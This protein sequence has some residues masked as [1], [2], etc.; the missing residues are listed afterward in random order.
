MEYTG[1]TIDRC[2]QIRWFV[3]MSSEQSFHFKIFPDSEGWRPWDIVWSLRFKGN[4]FTIKLLCQWSEVLCWKLNVKFYSVTTIKTL[5]QTQAV[6]LWFK[7]LQFSSQSRLIRNTDCYVCIMIRNSN[8]FCQWDPYCDLNRSTKWMDNAWKR[9][10]NDSCW[11]YFCCFLLS[12]CLLQKS[13]VLLC[14]YFRH[15]VIFFSQI[16]SN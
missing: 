12:C 11:C 15:S 14:V 9:T 5:N 8:A 3:I 13:F 7:Y 2:C 10:H 4:L 6:C 1:T 16:S